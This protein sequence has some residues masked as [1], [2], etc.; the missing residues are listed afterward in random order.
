MAAIAGNVVQFSVGVDNLGGS[1]AIYGYNPA[2]SAPTGTISATAFK[3]TTINNVSSRGAAAGSPYDFAIVL[4]GSLAQSFFD[5]VQVVGDSGVRYFHTS[6]ATHTVFGGGT[7]TSW[8]WGSGSPV[9]T[10]AAT[11]LML[12]RY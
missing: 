8:Q 4:D 11:R 3:T 10:S 6:T 1:P 12:L 9:W 7:L 5:S 2:S